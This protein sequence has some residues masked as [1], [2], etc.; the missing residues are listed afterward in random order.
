MTRISMVG[1]AGYTGPSSPRAQLLP[2]QGDTFGDI[3][4]IE[5]GMS[6]TG[7]VKLT[8]GIVV[9]ETGGEGCR[10]SKD[11]AVSGEMGGKRK[12]TPN[13]T[14]LYDIYYSAFTGAV[15]EEE[16]RKMV[17][18][19][20]GQELDTAEV[21]EELKG[22]R[23]WFRVKAREVE[24]TKTG[25]VYMLS[26]IDRFISAQEFAANAESGNHHWPN[27]EATRGNALPAGVAPNGAGATAR[28]GG[29]I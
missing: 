4:E 13:V 19:L 24:S 10:I 2:F 1:A 21:M 16:A 8:F 22:K 12:G 9:R 17:E 26:D 18:E 7:N 28:A 20:E 27:P 3:V 14:G 29:R 15:S 5:E 11:Q 23:V 6:K 25:E